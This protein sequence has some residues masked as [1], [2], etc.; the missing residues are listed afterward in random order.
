M[1]C[2]DGALSKDWLILSVRILS[3]SVPSPSCTRRR[4]FSPCS[5]L[6]PPTLGRW[7]Q[8]T[9]W[10]PLLRAHRRRSGGDGS[11][12]GDRPTLPIC[13]VFFHL[14]ISTQTIPAAAAAPKRRPHSAGGVFSPVSGPPRRRAAAVA[15]FRSRFR[16]PSGYPS[17]LLP[18]HLLFHGRDR[19]CPDRSPQRSGPTST[20]SAVAASTSAGR[21]RAR[22]RRPVEP[23]P[24]HEA[25]RHPAAGRPAAAAA[26]DDDGRHRRRRN[27][28]YSP[29]R[30]GSRRALLRPA[31]RRSRPQ[32]PVI[33]V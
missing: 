21:P 24:G 33:E 4:R 20:C 23:G 3:L 11:F 14:V 2:N 26:A 1:S 30:A 25:S 6:M 16:R 17:P 27:L 5:G 19:A 29:G 7:L 28:V 31:E 10:L 15:P 18:R 32:S 12:R 9:G 22:R 13:L 8:A